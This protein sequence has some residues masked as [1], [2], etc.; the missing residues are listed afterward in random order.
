MK[1]RRVMG[2]SKYSTSSGSFWK[3]DEWVTFPD[4]TVKRLRKFK[5][6]TKEQAVALAAKWRAEAFEGRFFDRPKV[7]KL[8]VAQL[9]EKYAPI[10]KRDKDSWRSD[11]ARAQY[12]TDFLG[13]RPAGSITQADV[14]EYRAFRLG[15]SE[16][17]RHR[18]RRRRGPPSP[19]SLDREL[20]QLKR[21]LNYAVEC[22]WL[23]SNPIAKVKLLNKPNVRRVTIDEA[24]FS[25]LYEV[26][27]P[28]LKPIILT[29]YDTGMR[30][31]EILNL[32]WSQ[33]DLREG[34]VKLSAEDTKTNF[35]RTVY[36]T[37]RV[38]ETLKAIPRRLGTEYVFV[39]P[40]TGTR[41]E[42][43]RK[44]YRRA[45]RRLGLGHLWFHDLRRSFV[46][47]A[48]R[49]GVPE[50]VCMR[51][52]GHRTRNVFDR[53]NIVED[54]DVRNAVKVIEAGAARDLQVEAR[55]A[56]GQDLDTEGG[57]TP[58]KHESPTGKCP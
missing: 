31:G 16:S 11:V 7:V 20:A 42:D 22:G 15:Q 50:S 10:S 52:S 49:R 53:Y 23:A 28:A 2:V 8:T 26:A 43:A 14:D 44:L 51:M 37:A 25:K 17:P 19:A 18:G 9:W 24:T 33:L 29:A 46:T 57:G 36:L 21:M 58:R 4:G 47:N 56:L 13:D 5:I 30:K 1:R 39:N 54:E 32:R 34:A 6:P 40:E 45:C 38:V 3:A 55:V 12:L 41:W 27:D 48:R 35:P